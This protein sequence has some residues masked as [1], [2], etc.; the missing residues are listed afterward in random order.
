MMFSIIVPVYNEENTILEILTRL[1]KLKF[2]SFKKA[3][4]LKMDLQIIQKKY[5]NNKNLYN[6]IY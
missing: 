6:K 5:E 2:L 1:E 3:L 4:L